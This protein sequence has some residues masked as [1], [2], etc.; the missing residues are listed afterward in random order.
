MR[1]PPDG[2]QWLIPE[3][4]LNLLAG[5]AAKEVIGPLPNGG[6]KQG[7]ALPHS[8]HNVSLDPDR[9]TFVG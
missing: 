3:Y 4:Y 7:S 2:F 9:M 6:D 1:S 5:F 8:R